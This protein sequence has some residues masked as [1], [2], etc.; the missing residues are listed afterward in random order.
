ME[1]AGSPPRRPAPSRL[2]PTPPNSH[3][4]RKIGLDYGFRPGVA[5][6][7]LR[8][9]I[10]FHYLFAQ[11]TMGLALLIFI[12]KTMAL[13]TGSEHYQRAP[14]FWIR[15]FALPSPSAW[16]RRPMEFQFGTNWAASR[17]WPAA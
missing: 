15:I 3:N 4:R 1:R 14:A 13:R 9:H 11:L 7:S 16:S 6:V 5:P 12:L 2:A 8:L 10:T 17:R